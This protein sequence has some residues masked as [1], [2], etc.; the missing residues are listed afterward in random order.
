MNAQP[1]AA[2]T[3]KPSSPRVITPWLTGSLVI[4]LISGAIFSG[5]LIFG[6]GGLNDA[7]FRAQAA[8]S[9]LENSR[10]G[11]AALQTEVSALTKRK[12]DLTPI[13]GEYEQRLKEKAAAEVALTALEEKQR[14]AASDLTRLGKQLEQ[15]NKETLSALMQQADVKTE[16][17]KLR[18]D[19]VAATKTA[20][21]A[22]AQLQSQLDQLKKDKE[23]LEAEIAKLETQK[24]SIVAGA[25]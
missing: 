25:K 1:K 16:I 24:A 6:E 22:K 19:L 18:A 11:L 14:L 3:S 17:E 4:S 8:R 15:T 13:V 7:Q 20:E 9:S 2:V 23:R 21:E 5:V 10:V 12:H